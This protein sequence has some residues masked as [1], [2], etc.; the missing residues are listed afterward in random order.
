[1]IR[2][3]QFR[4]E[5]EALSW[6]SGGFD[7]M[8]YFFFIACRSSHRATAAPTERDA[9]DPADLVGAPPAHGAEGDA[10]ARACARAGAGVVGECDE[11]RVVVG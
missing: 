2:V 4:S 1:M 6:D 5:E 11:G 7:A 10:P 9:I 8:T 3:V